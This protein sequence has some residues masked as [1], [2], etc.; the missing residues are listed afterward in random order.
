MVLLLKHFVE[1]ASIEL[2]RSTPTIPDQLQSVLDQYDF[3]GNIRELESMVFDAVNRTTT[4]VLNLQVFENKLASPKKGSKPNLNLSEEKTFKM[5]CP[6]RGNFPTMTEI[7]DRLITMALD[8][9][10]GNQTV[11]AQ[12]LGISRQ[13][14]NYKVKKIKGK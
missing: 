11:A 4:N 12:L 2:E 14:L 10:D 1:V 13:A 8:Y 9:A 5:E 6:I 7:N 3:P